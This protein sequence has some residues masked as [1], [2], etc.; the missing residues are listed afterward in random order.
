MNPVLPSFS[1]PPL[2]SAGRATFAQVRLASFAGLAVVF[3]GCVVVEKPHHTVVKPAPVH[4][5]VVDEPARAAVVV[6]VREAPP[7]LRRE[8]I[9]E[10][11][12]PSAAHAWIKGHWRHDGRVYVWVP[13]HW[14]R[15]PRANVVWVEPRWERRG[16][17]YIFIEGVWK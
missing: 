14:E 8:V 9:V 1:S 2:E 11:E 12:R 17:V 3:S 13:G 15:P 7:P 6:E 5:V 10:R 16:G 4:V